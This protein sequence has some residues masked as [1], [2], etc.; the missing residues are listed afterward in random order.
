MRKAKSPLDVYMYLPNDCEKLFGKS[1]M[2]MA[3]DLVS[4]RIRLSEIKDALLSQKTPESVRDFEALTEL[5]QPTIS[6]IQIGVGERAVTIGGDDV[7]FRHTLS[8]YNKTP[9]AVDVWDTMSDAALSER[10]DKIQSFKKFYVGEFLYLDMIAVR[11]VSNNPE[12][13][14]KCVAAI[15][16]KSNM[17]LILCTKN[18]DVMRAGLAAAAGQNP[19]MYACDM[20]NRME[21]AKLALEFDVPLVV[22]A[23]GDLNELKSLAAALQKAGVTKLVLDPGAGCGNSEIG[24]TFLNFIQIR[25]AAL[26]GDADL[27]YPLIALPIASWRRSAKE[28]RA[29]AADKS[30]MESVLADAGYFE[31]M[32]ATALTVRYADIMIIHGLEP[33]E[34]LPLLHVTKMIYTDPRTPASVEPKMYTIGNPT[35]ESPVLFT[36]NFALTFYTVESD[37]ASSNVDCYLLS[38]NTGGLGVE[39]AVAGGQLTAGV[40]QAGFENAAFDFDAMACKTLILP[41]LAARLQNDIEKEMKVSALV[42]PMDSGRLVKWLEENWPPKNKT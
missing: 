27:A 28:I 37:L 3:S 34:V 20:K 10:V 8:F 2:T 35:H 25:K 30:P 9:I 1:K 17:P 22:S 19:L 42:G 14:G 29:S 18:A 39:A 41:G 40:I 26:D 16:K 12:T 38:V 32:T 33:Y 31:T 36:T 13:F 11:S 7:M 6:E 21:M 4:R 23:N 15:L 5:L 24:Q